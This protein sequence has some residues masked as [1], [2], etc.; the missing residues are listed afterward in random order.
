MRIQLPFLQLDFYLEQTFASSFS[1]ATSKSSCRLNQRKPWKNEKHNQQVG[2]RLQNYTFL[3]MM[4]ELNVFMKQLT[5]VRVGASNSKVR[6]EDVI[7]Q[8]NVEG[9]MGMASF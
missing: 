1:M 7:T 3:A 4:E 9:S 8:A 2:W 5:C 6:K